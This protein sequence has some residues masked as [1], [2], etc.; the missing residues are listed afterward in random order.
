MTWDRSWE[1]LGTTKQRSC[2][3][4]RPTWTATNRKWSSGHFY[5]SMPGYGKDG[6]KTEGENPSQDLEVW[7]SELK[8][9]DKRMLS[10]Y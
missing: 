4:H 6:R 1:E 7:G 10:L 8:P 5:P 9:G 3:G 2:C